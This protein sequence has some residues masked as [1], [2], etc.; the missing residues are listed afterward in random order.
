MSGFL[1]VVAALNAEAQC[2]CKAERGVL[3]SISGMGA[4]R[5]RLAAARLVQE[6]AQ[7]LAS[8]GIAAGLA[9]GLRAGSLVLPQC[10]VSRGVQITVDEHWRQ[11][12]LSCLVERF[13]VYS[14]AIAHTPVALSSCAQKALLHA[15]TEAM[16]ADMES[17]AVA[18]VARKAG[19]PFVAIRAI[20][21]PFDLR[22]PHCALNAVDDV[23][24][25]KLTKLLPGLVRSPLDL[26]PLIKLGIAFHQALSTLRYVSKRAGPLLMAS[27]GAVVTE[28]LAAP[29]K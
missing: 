4:D 12:L 21:D 8:W 13:P 28:L 9:E 15:E 19:L 14:G 5:A 27:V 10:V 1:G 20:A 26:V 7:A 22:L 25:S 16:A 6:G 2:L 17:M 29:A 11:R 24:K 3:L 23:G 18:Q